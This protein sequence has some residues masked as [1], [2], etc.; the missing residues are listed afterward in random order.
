MVSE[1]VLLMMALAVPLVAVCNHCFTKCVCVVRAAACD[2]TARLAAAIALATPTLM[3]HAAWPRGT[4]LALV[5][6]LHCMH[7]QRQ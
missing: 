6:K 1:Q 2:D 5:T 4:W 7:S 3:N